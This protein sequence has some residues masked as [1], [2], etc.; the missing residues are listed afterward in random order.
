MSWSSAPPEHFGWLH[1]ATVLVLEL[2]AGRG[3]PV[4]DSALLDYVQEA[5]DDAKRSQKDAWVAE[6]YELIGQTSRAALAARGILHALRAAAAQD[7]AHAARHAAQAASCAV[8][9]SAALPEEHHPDEHGAATSTVLWREYQTLRQ[10]ALRE[11]WTDSTPVP[12]DLF[13]S[14]PFESNSD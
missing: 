1:R 11:S 6:D 3:E 5:L 12:I 7:T 9:S 14:S 4:E 8:D 2:C 10:A 13:G